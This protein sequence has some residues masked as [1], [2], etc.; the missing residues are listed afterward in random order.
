MA[1]VSFSL[2]LG[3]NAGLCVAIHTSVR[4]VMINPLVMAVWGQIVA[5]CEF[6]GACRFSSA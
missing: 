4:A 6:V 3:R 1:V 5:A 2:L